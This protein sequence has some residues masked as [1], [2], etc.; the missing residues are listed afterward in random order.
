MVYIL[1]QYGVLDNGPP[2]LLTF[3]SDSIQNLNPNVIP[4]N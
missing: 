1:L 4:Q 3:C 2:Y